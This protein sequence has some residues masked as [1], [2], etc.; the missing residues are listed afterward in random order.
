MLDKNN[1]S[2]I[3][4]INVWADDMLNSLLENG[5]TYMMVKEA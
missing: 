2:E 3:T 5:I 1:G 4:D